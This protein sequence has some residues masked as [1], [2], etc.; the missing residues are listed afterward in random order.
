M[1]V[2]DNIRTFFKPKPEAKS[3]EKKAVES[4]ETKAAEARGKKTKSD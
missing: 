2:L 4:P 1:T 3:A